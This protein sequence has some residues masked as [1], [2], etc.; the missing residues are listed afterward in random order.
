MGAL[1]QYFRDLF[2]GWQGIMSSTASIVFLII[3]FYWRLAE[4]GQLRYW[5][6]ASFA[7]F[8]VAA[9]WAWHLQYRENQIGRQVGSLA[10][11]GLQLGV[12][13]HEEVAD[14][15]VKI[16]IRNLQPRLLKYRIEN[17]KFVVEDQEVNNQMPSAEHFIYGN[18]EGLFICSGIENV[19]LNKN[20]LL[21]SLEYAS[22][23]RFVGS[24]HLHHSNKKLALEIV[25]KISHSA[26]SIMPT[27]ELHWITRGEHED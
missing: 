7:C 16:M 4:L 25:A 3:G 22:S 24:K 9:F 15:Q 18:R 11:E 6:A 27:A 14:I 1:K 5:L 20:P 8:F 19:P 10:F 17:Y 2:T 26:G 21:G 23:Y 13:W 12:N